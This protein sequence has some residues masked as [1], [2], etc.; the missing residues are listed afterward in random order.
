MFEE[1]K[2]EILRE[3][4]RDTNG[5]VVGAMSNIL[6]NEEFLNFGVTI[7]HIKHIATQ[8]YPNHALALDMFNSKIREMK[9]CAIYIDE[10]SEV[11]IEQMNEWSKS[12]IS[13]D[14][15]EHSATMLFFKANDSLDVAREW[16]KDGK[17]NVLHYSALLMANKRAKIKYQTEDSEDYIKDRGNYIIIV[18]RALCYVENPQIFRVLCSLLA[19]LS[20]ADSYLSEEIKN[21]ELSDAIRSEIDW[22]C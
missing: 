15:A 1:V 10:G 11:S 5:A 6:G 16:L 2:K 19:N 9:L 12:F 14:I 20:K 13:Q 3:M 8:Y 18:N 22:Q 7:S 21:M 17:S 4:R